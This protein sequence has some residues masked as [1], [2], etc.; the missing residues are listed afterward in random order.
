M[1]DVVTAVTI[2]QKYMDEHFFSPAFSWDRHEFKKRSYQ[3]WACYEICER[4][5][6]H[7]LEQPIDVIERFMFEMYMYACYGG[8]NKQQ[9]F[10]FQTAVETA[11]EII[12]LFV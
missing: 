1:C 11:E 9:S 7:P 12:L 5:M 8:E 6:D 2:I 4:I 3:Q 10:I